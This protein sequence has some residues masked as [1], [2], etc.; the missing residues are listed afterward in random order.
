MTSVR[1][2]ATA[3]FALQGAAVFVWWA[4]LL[5][6]PHSR[7]WFRMGHSDAILLAFW[8]P[9]AVL[10]GAG[11]LVASALCFWNS[12]LIPITLWG[13]CGAVCY[14]TL[15]CLAFAFLTDTGWLGVTF[16]CPALVWSGVFAV[17]LSPLR[18]W[19]FRTARPSGTRWIVA[20]TALQI[21]V[22]WTLILFV[23]PALI[24]QVEDKLGVLRVSLTHQK[25][26]SALFFLL[27]SLPGL[28]SAWL[29]SKVG[30]GTPL[31][32]DAASRL[33]VIG[34]YAWVRNP[35]AI[36]GVGQGIA[37]ALW[38]G[39]PLVLI[40][41][42]MGAFVWQVV[43]RPLEEADLLAKFGADYDHY[44]RAVPCWTL[45]TQRYRGEMPVPMGDNSV[46]EM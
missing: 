29:M 24:L 14:A 5:G 22:V 1:Q 19:M 7:N 40:Y 8:L 36:S 6:A 41:A 15:Y 21:V 39:S 4:L 20:K 35:M 44:R 18:D 26:L 10:M 46:V 12:K 30:R 37:V 23:I 17:A 33:V 2:W 38:H 9:D 42:I 16:M 32:M 13:I 28:W 25:P 3:Y 34:A 27:I 43:F 45:R 11:S 31:P